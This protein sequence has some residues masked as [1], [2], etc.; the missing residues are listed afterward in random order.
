MKKSIYETMTD[1]AI[2]ADLSSRI[3]MEQK[4]ERAPWW[5]RMF[6][7]KW[8]KMKWPT[9]TFSHETAD[10]AYQTNKQRAQEFIHET[11]APREVISVPS[12]DPHVEG[13]VWNNKG[14]LSLSAGDH[15]HFARRGKAA[16]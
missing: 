3:A 10:Y 15:I 7:Y 2:Y 8:R 4:W 6:G 11:F 5:A 12:A 16:K 1:G 14:V 9:D 13:A